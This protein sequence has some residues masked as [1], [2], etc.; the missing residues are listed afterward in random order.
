MDLTV[1]IVSY[2]T[3]DLLLQSINSI[4]NNTKDISYE[5]IVVD[6]ASNDNSVT[7]V[8]KFKRKKKLNIKVLKNKRNLGFGKANNQGMR[9]SK[10]RYILLLN[11]DTLIHDDVLSKMI[12]WMDKNKDIGISS[13]ALKNKDG[14]LQG[15]GGYFP[16]LIRVF[17]WMIIQDL[18]FVDKIIKPFHPVHSKFFNIGEK[19]Y[20]KKRELDWLT[21]AFLL[22]RKEV[23][24]KTG[25]FDEDFFMYAEDVDL[26]YRAK[27]VGFRIY[28]NP[29]WSITHYGGKSGSSWSFVL[30]EFEGLRIFYKKHFPSWQYPFLR[31]FL[32]IGALIRVLLFGIFL[33]K[34]GVKTYAKALITV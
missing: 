22:M 25:G 12:F 24:E 4:V 31:T 29:K 8:L 2:N 3:K 28:Y 21:G 23:F 18:P 20:Q 1:V 30:P 19:F 13:C 17:S 14:S 16:T 11:S 5:I 32:K 10:A 9:I 33:E 15:T 6:N 27:K 34:E 7:E 26:C